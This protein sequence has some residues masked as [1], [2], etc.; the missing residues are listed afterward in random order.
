MHN[1]TKD[2]K[3]FSAV[4]VGDQPLVPPEVPKGGTAPEIALA[5]VARLG[6]MRRPRSRVLHQRRTPA[7]TCSPTHSQEADR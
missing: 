1:A 6:T 7:K 5:A 2:A 3:S 4:R